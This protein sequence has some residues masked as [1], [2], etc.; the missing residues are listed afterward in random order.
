[1]MRAWKGCEERKRRGGEGKKGAKEG[2]SSL[3]KL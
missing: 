1:M 3:R 2:A